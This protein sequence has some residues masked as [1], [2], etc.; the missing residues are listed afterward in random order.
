MKNNCEYSKLKYIFFEIYDEKSD[1]I[2]KIYNKLINVAKNDDKKNI[3]LSNI[4]NLIE[5]RKI[6][7]NN[8]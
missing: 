1:D 6:M 4:L 8:S 7:S 2:E 3:K 5:N